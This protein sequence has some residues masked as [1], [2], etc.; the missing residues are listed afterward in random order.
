V[1]LRIFYPAQGLQQ[2]NEPSKS[3][4]RP[5]VFFLNFHHFFK[6]GKPRG[7]DPATWYGSP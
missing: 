2:N 4:Q 1:N 5:P 6:Q 3:L 7:R